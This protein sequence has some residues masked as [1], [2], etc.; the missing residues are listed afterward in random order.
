M[1][2]NSVERCWPTPIGIRRWAQADSHQDTL[3]RILRMIRV[4]DP[5]AR[6]GSA[7]YVS[8]DDLLERIQVPEWRAL[9]DFI[10]SGVTETVATAN[11][12][13]WGSER[14]GLRVALRGLWCQMSN[15]GTHH[16]VHTHGNCSWSG[17]YCVDVDSPE[18][19]AAHPVY[20][21]RNGVTRFYGP[22]AQAL[23]GAFAD[24]GTAYLQDATLDVDPIPGQLIVFPSWL[25]HQAMPYAGERDRVILSFNVSIH[26]E[27][28]SDEGRPYA[29]G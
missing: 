16:D 25:P 11:A 20:A 24:F 23:G 5:T 19:R 22:Y 6:A 12:S 2:I 29:N 7:F 10:V 15:G 17:V 27:A 28:G 18:I 26:R 4:T 14:P 3:L 13:Q 21:G 9:V 8:R 1:S